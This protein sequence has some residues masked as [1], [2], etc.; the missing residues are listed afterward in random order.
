[1][2]DICPDSGAIPCEEALERMYEFLDGELSNDSA[3]EVRVHL[4]RCKKCYPY[5][6]FERVFLDHVRSLRL[7]PETTERLEARIRKALDDT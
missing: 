6:N 7:P 2:S 5:F 3:E 4:E 1:M